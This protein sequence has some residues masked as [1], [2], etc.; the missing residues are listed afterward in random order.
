MVGKN[1]ISTRGLKE[2]WKGTD[3]DLIDCLMELFSPDWVGSKGE[4]V[5]TILAAYRVGVLVLK[6]LLEACWLYFLIRE[7]NLRS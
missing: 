1:N 2:N 7:L 4:I 3:L 6:I 5:V